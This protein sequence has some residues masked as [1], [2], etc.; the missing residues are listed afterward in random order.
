MNSIQG[1]SCDTY[2]SRCDRIIW[3]TTVQPTQEEEEFIID[4]S[5]R[6]KIGLKGLFAIARVFR[7]RSRPRSQDSAVFPKSSKE[8]TPTSSGPPQSSPL[9]R[10]AHPPVQA[11]LNHSRSHEDLQSGKATGHGLRKQSANRLR[12]INSAIVG[13][14]SGDPSVKP[15]RRSTEGPGSRRRS[16]MWG[17]LNPFFP[18]SPSP[19]AS[20]VELIPQGPRRPRKGDVVCL[21][22][23]TLDDRGMHRLEGRSD[24]RPVMGAFGVYL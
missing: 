7:P 21:S 5:T 9:S 2:V 19:S 14:S 8:S 12:R 11:T 13:T 6:S 18:S 3:K 4:S 20:T 23:N 22:Y 24:H 17:F 1:H 16:G 15:P 10:I